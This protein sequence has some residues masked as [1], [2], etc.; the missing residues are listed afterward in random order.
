MSGQSYDETLL[1]SAPAA[2]KAQ[3][4]EG[5]TTD[6]LHS[7]AGNATPPPF[8]ASQAD[9]EQG[10]A[11]KESNGAATTRPVSFWRT[12]KGLTIIVI[13]VIVV[14]AAV[15]GGAVGGTVGKNKK[16]DTSSS[17]GTGGGGQSQGS[18]GVGASQGIGGSATGST[19]SQSTFSVFQSTVQT[20]PATT[21]DSA[22][23]ATSEG[24]GGTAPTT[25][26]HPDA[27]ILTVGLSQG[28]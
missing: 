14:L 6:I 25:T 15:I 17:I 21:D 8:S 3:L 16:T 5:Y 9:V 12:A 27:N 28:R 24:I 20:Q 23:T 22:P 18:G 26:S 19:A 13:A 1:A 10:F 11:H 2:T 7:S 4:Q